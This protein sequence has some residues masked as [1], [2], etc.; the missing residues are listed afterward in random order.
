M[1]MLGAS[2][3]TASHSKLTQFS[4]GYLVFSF[5]DFLHVSVYLCLGHFLGMATPIK[6]GHV[7]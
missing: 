6:K 1:N 4:Y 2:C 7:I 3:Y 5:L